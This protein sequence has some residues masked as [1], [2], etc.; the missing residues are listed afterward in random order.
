LP[1]GEVKAAWDAREGLIGYRLFSATVASLGLIAVLW[2]AR[3]AGLPPWA[4][5][6]CG[7]LAAA[8]PILIQDAHYGRPEAFVTTL[9]LVVVI[10]AWPREQVSWAAIGLSAFGCGLLISA[11]IS[12]LPLAWIP[13]VPL[14]AQWQRDQ[15]GVARLALKLTALGLIAALGFFVGAP[16]AV[17]APRQFVWGIRQLQKQ[18]AL[19]NPPFGHKD[20]SSVWDLMF[21]YF[22]GTFGLATLV[23]AF[24]GGLA[25][26]IQRKWMIVAVLAGPVLLTVFTFGRQHVFF[27]RNLSHIVPLGIILVGIGA[28]WMIERIQLQ[29]VR[30]SAMVAIGVV[31]LWCP[32]SVSK[33]LLYKAFSGESEREVAAKIEEVQKNHQEAK[34]VTTLG[35]KGKNQILEELHR[36]VHESPRKVVLLHTVSY[37]DPWTKENEEA[38]RQEFEVTELASRPSDFPELPTST[39][40]V[41]ASPWHRLWL[42]RPGR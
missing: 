39:L 8:A 31:T 42:V 5:L 2:L 30:F 35:A 36:H 10:C 14:L 34:W 37:G 12:F 7:A 6:L 20:R 26:L 16:G 11:K 18:Y 15:E 22:A 38:I 27:E 23:L 4:A 13:A 1:V 29:W 28:T 21:G 41:Y 32:V 40:Q 17:L 25:L 9:L 33:R 24:I 3:L 19:G